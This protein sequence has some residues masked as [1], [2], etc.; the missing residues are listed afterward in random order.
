[1]VYANIIG[2]NHL[3]D[4]EVPVW[5]SIPEDMDVTL[6]S[7]YINEQEPIVKV[8][9]KSG[10]PIEDALVC[11]MNSEVYSTGLTDSDGE[12][13]LSMNAQ[14]T[15]A[16]SIT[17]TAHNFLPFETTSA[18]DNEP[19]D[20]VVDPLDLKLSNSTPSEGDNLIIT[21]D[22]FNE[23]SLPASDVNIKCYD[24]DP[25]LDGIQI[26][27]RKNIP[28][29]NVNNYGTVKFQWNATHGN[30]SIYVVADPDDEIVESDEYNNKVSMS[31]YVNARPKLARLPDVNLSED[32]LEPVSI[33]IIPYASD[34]DDNMTDLKLTV[35]R[36]TNPQCN[37][38]ITTNSILLITIATNWYGVASANIGISDGLASSERSFNINVAPSP[39]P[40]FL[41]I[42]PDA[43]IDAGEKF[44][45]F[46]DAQDPDGDKLVF[47]DDTD[48]FEIDPDS[49]RI[50]FTG[51]EDDVGKHTVTIT[52]SDG[53]LTDSQSF[54]IEIEGGIGAE[55]RLLSSVAI[56]ISIIVIIVI[57]FIY[58][59]QGKGDETK[60]KKQDKPKTV[61]ATKRSKTKEKKN[62]VKSNKPKK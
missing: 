33:N 12:A 51:E 43:K 23:G 2:Y 25:Y 13:K 28:S 39:D 7:F 8:T 17:V 54:R 56:L 38:T 20:L 46:A 30:H 35:S 22:V 4:P 58:L 21:I 5:T 49:G 55:N 32:T 15:G 10:S 50:S 34:L 18:I 44:L 31:V 3:G 36:V 9:S 16:L 26:D 59:R 52:V 48:L 11:A 27:V 6:P 37:V 19:P 41:D 40:P 61:K 62:K 24:G 57:L 53:N 60:N 45:Y 47:S 1:M 14:N 42:I 29:I